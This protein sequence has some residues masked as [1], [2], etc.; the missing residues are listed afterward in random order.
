MKEN[1]SSVRDNHEPLDVPRL[2]SSEA[3]KELT[4]K[5]AKLYIFCRWQ[6]WEEKDRP[7]KDYPDIEEY[8]RPGVFY[9]NWGK[10]HSKGLYNTNRAGFYH[11]VEALCRYGFIKRLLD[12]KTDRVKSVYS[13][14]DSWLDYRAEGEERIHKGA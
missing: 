14:S 11:D 2:F 1:N 12:G 8:Q 4:G 10:V 7:G 6:R 13:L 5:Q 9:L 3:W